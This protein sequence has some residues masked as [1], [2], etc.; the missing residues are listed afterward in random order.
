MAEKDRHTLSAILLQL[1]YGGM[2]CDLALLTGEGQGSPHPYFPLILLIYAPLI[3]GLNR[4]VL[5]RQRTVY[6]LT[7]VNGALFALALGTSLWLSQLR[8]LGPI[9]FAIAAC[10]LPAISGV[11]FVVRPPKLNQLILTLD[12]SVILLV[13]YVGY[14]AYYS[15]SF[16]WTLPGLVGTAAAL[17][18]LV[19]HRID[20]AM[21]PR[22]LG[23]MGGLLLLMAA[24]LSLV[25]IFVAPGAGGG[26]VALWGGLL[27]LGRGFLGLL[28]KFLKLIAFLFP[29]GDGSF[30]LEAEENPLG[31]VMEAESSSINTGAVVGILVALGII[32]L[33][34]M[35]I[36]VFG[37]LKVGRK[38]VNAIG[39]DAPRRR[40]SLADSMRALLARWSLR[41]RLRRFLRTNR[42]TPIGLFYLLEKSCARTAWRRAPEETPREFL[43]RLKASLPPEENGALVLDTLIPAVDAALFGSGKNPEIVGGA[44][45]RKLV[46][47]EA[48]KH[49]VERRRQRKDPK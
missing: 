8:G 41:R 17:L 24:V 16:V 23:L 34:V 28:E 38:R 39:P 45:L 31:Q 27:A 37:K 25:V 33:A 49:R 43:T 14:S 19:A 36:I 42:N 47:R 6:F 20:R 4:L 30:N 12:G 26:M 11:Y 22:E 44:H 32:V 13:F 46:R 7:A 29:E 21:G 35:A 40:P 3:Y 15:G 1:A 10:L 18:G 5:R 9:L 48:G 2:L